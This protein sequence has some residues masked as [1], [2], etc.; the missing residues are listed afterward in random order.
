VEEAIQAEDRE[1]KAEE[2]A[3]DEDEFI[4]DGLD[5]GWIGSGFAE[6]SFAVTWFRTVEAGDEDEADENEDGGD[7][8][9]GLTRW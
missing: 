1:D 9:S 7:H 6:S 3:G 8:G 5:L 4:H 2:E